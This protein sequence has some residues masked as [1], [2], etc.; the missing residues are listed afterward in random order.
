MKKMNFKKV[1]TVMSLGAIFIGINVNNVMA[2]DAPKVISVGLETVAKNV[3]TMKIENNTLSIGVINENGEFQE[4]GVLKTNGEFVASVS[5]S[6]YVGLEGAF[7][8]SEAEQ[9]SSVLRGQGYSSYVAFLG[10]Q[11]F[12]VYVHGTTVE[13]VESVTGRTAVSVPKSLSYQVSGTTTATFI[14]P[15]QYGGVLKGDGEENTFKIGGKSYRGYLSFA[16]N[17][18]VLTPVNV[19]DIDEY[20]YGV[21]PA[22]M[23]ISYHNEALKAQA[24]AARTYAISKEGEH[25]GGDY[26]TCDKVHCQV[27]GGFSIEAETTTNAVNETSG[28]LALYEGEPI[29]A[30]FYA[31]SGGYTENSEDVWYEPLPYLRAIEEIIPEDD[32]SWTKTFTT[33]QMSS[34]TS[35]GTVSDVIITK[36]ATGGRIQELKFVGSSGSKVM[37][38]D[39]FRNLTGI[40]SKMFTI[41]GLGG[42]IGTYGGAYNGNMNLFESVTTN[43]ETSGNVD[44]L[45]AVSKGIT[46]VTEGELEH[47][48]GTTLQFSYDGIAGLVN[49]NLP[50][51]NNVGNVGDYNIQ[52]VSISTKNGTGNYILE[53]LGN[54][55]GV[56]LSQKGAEAMAN[57]G[58]NYRQILTHYYTGITIQ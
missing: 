22:E 6:A 8:Q 42:E 51:L 11:G 19:V 32:A 20:L 55:H 40:N 35:V 47:L 15:T 53:G 18:T 50:G 37:S 13:A 10:N 39:D 28:E 3:S 31:S 46:L 44:F 23:Y 24:V 36:L 26:L 54:G 16:P 38:G 12:N 17:G 48:N 52:S 34:I 4:Y 27:Y 30:F 41:N 1:A 45:G 2:Y 14:F 57:A 43:A 29:E 49:N 5:T 33:S 9:I 56:G 58:Y 21:V 7:S 25:S